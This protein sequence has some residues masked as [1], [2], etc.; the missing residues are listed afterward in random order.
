MSGIKFN[1]CRWKNFL[2][3]G[4]NFIEITLNDS[5]STLIIGEN[6]AGKSTVLDALTF[7][8]FGRAFRNVN[9]PQLVNSI[10]NND[11][12]VEVDFT[13]G[14]KNYL[15]RRGIKPAFF[16]IYINNKI[17]DQSANLRDYQELLEKQILKLN[18]KSFTQ[19]VVLG[20]S[21][22]IPF[23]QLKAADRRI[24]IEDLLDIQIFSIMSLLL[25]NRTIKNKDELSKL[26]SALELYENNIK[27]YNTILEDLKTD[28]SIRIKENLKDIEEHENQLEINKNEVETLL[29]TNQTL[30]E[31]ISDKSIIQEKVNSLFDYEKSIKKNI[32]KQFQ[33]IE[34]YE[35]NVECGTCHQP[36]EIEFRNSKVR[37]SQNREQEYT[38]ALLKLTQEIEQ[39]EER[40]EEIEKVNNNIL[41][42][43]SDISK[44][45]N[46]IQAIIKYVEKVTKQN[47]EIENKTEDI[48]NKKKNIKELKN[49]LQNTNTEKNILIEERYL[50]ELAS[51]MLKDS[52][53]KTRIIKQY[54][55]IMNKLINKYLSQ[56]DFFASFNLDENFNEIIKSRYRDEFTYS[57]F[58]EGEKIRIDLA[59]L[60]TWRSIAKLK[61][62]ANTNLLILDEVF[63]SSLDS[64][65]T[66]DFL[67]ILNSLSRDINVFIIS[68]K[69]DVLNDKFT[70][71]IKFEKQKN[72]SRINNG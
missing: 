69:G 36:L 71:V 13:I 64:D 41:S 3:T 34:F 27:V 58:S 6:G 44:H 1:S 62:S 63:D 12:V 43:Q 68:H 56:L 26:N 52:G 49:N 50:H 16:E 66:E 15:V 60:F 29:E 30:S 28:K 2:S 32:Q 8:L 42:N 65:G 22:F 23:M 48:E 45:Q 72:F 20:S 9:K 24:I 7:S 54:L 46:S 40:L 19:I 5:P 70:N 59:L 33:N 67:K 11:C 10:N 53:I 39:R 35:N 4:N 57:S 25:K 55:P 18:Y 51:M 17:I 38:N 47:L 37:E 21:S 61:N 14:T 31:S